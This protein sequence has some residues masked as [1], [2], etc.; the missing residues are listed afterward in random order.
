MSNT[1]SNN[2]N[3]S[4]AS[5]NQGWQKMDLVELCQR[6]G[7]NGGSKELRRLMFY[8]RSKG[9]AGFE[10]NDLGRWPISPEFLAQI[11][12][13]KDGVFGYLLSGY[14]ALGTGIIP[15]RS[16]GMGMMQRRGW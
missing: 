1:P 15:G 6:I 4:S 2:N 10:R 9:L 7:W 8:A 5:N 14:R 12:A 16:F 11:D 3:I 13:A